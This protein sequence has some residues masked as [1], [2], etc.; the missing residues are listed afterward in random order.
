M[1]II[2]MWDISYCILGACHIW[3]NIFGEG[4][5]GSDPNGRGIFGGGFRP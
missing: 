5:M 2:D 4:T 1:C 3:K